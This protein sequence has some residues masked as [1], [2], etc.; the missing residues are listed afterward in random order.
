MRHTR[1]RLLATS[2]SLFLTAT[3]FAQT[4][5]PSPALPPDPEVVKLK[6][7]KERLDAEKAL[8]DSRKAL[9]DAQ[10]ALYLADV[11]KNAKVPAGDIAS[12]D[13]YSFPGYI[14]AL[15][16]AKAVAT[17]L[18]AILK[19]V[20][21]RTAT[22]TSPST[23]NTF[24]LVDNALLASMSQTQSLS[25]DLE[26]RVKRV[27][28]SLKS[29]TES[30]SRPPGPTPMVGGLAGIAFGLDVLGGLVQSV[31]GFAQ[32][33]RSDITYAAI[34]VDITAADVAA[35][36]RNC[37]SPAPTVV[38]PFEMV[39]V[40]RSPLLGQLAEAQQKI[41][42]LLVAVDTKIKELPKDAGGGAAGKPNPEA[43]RLAGIKQS[44]EKIQTDW[45]TLMSG[46]T[47]VD[48]ETKLS[49]LALMERNQFVI[50][51]LANNGNDWLLAIA[52]RRAGATT[53]TKKSM[54]SNKQHFA[55]GISVRYQVQDTAGN[56]SQSGIVYGHS[57]WFPVPD[58]RDGKVLTGQL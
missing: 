13:K 19:S 30:L 37:A 53:R 58:D 57:N 52:V 35:M 2:L 27:N 11:A 31:A 29:I 48:T 6:A 12:A 42:A 33:F 34:E 9:L 14:A 46:L 15:T 8:L 47:K 5:A 3:A 26:Q 43:T 38:S 1:A 10:Q 56:V 18:C 23:S 39:S 17:K 54:F 36:L 24:Y 44:V 55:G 32:L 28:D 51:Q 20:T 25:F 21:A 49:P 7:E 16:E 22:E 45:A 4:S 41:D 40:P 50:E